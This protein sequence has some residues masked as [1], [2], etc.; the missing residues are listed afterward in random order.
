MVW[1]ELP[2][3]TRSGWLVRSEAGL[4]VGGS[5]AWRGWRRGGVAAAFWGMV[6]GGSL[7]GGH[8]PHLD[9]LAVIP[10][11]VRKTERSGTVAD[12]PCVDNG[13]PNVRE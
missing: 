6:G 8:H 9:E 2:A 13:C 7:W 4:W 10:G 5:M 3:L 11:V 12:V 1:V